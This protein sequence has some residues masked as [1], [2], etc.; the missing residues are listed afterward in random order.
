MKEEIITVLGTNYH[1]KIGVAEADDPRLKSCDGLTDNSVKEI[2]V[3]K[4]VPDEQSVGDLEEYTR[5]VIR[6]ELIHAFLYESGLDC[7]SDWARNEEIIDWIAI[8][9]PKLKDL[10]IYNHVEN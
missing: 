1:L 8:Q 5:K 6:H 4:F 9:F 7:N 2:V 10:F 3:G